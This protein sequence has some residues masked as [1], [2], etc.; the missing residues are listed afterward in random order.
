MPVSIAWSTPGAAL[1]A[2][3]GVIE[4]GFP[5]AV[6]RFIICAILIIIAGL[7]R[8]LGKAVA[9]IPA[10]LANAML[11]GVIIGLCFAPIKAIGF[12]PALG[13]P[14]ILARIVVGSL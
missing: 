3:T 10:P 13:L 9:S 6:G 1:L 2:T 14:I 7:F 11:S 8:P 5:A 4:G 12:N